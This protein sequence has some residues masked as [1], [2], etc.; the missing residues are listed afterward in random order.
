MALVEVYSFVTLDEPSPEINMAEKTNPARPPMTAIETKN[1][2][3]APIA[4]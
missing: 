2:R 4:R 1:G 3:T